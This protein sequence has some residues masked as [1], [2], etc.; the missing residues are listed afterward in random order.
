VL[1][2]G[3]TFLLPKPNNPIEHLWVVITERDPSTHE[4]VCVNISSTKPY[5]LQAD[6]TL[7][8]VAGEHSCI[9]KPSV[10]FYKDARVMRLN[11]VDKMLA[12]TQ[13]TIVCVQK[14]PC[15]TELLEKIQKHLPN[16]P[17]NKIIK[18]RCQAMWESKT[19]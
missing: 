11:D 13:Q 8:L 14:E 15:S 10:V 2:L 16:S 7:E 18:E 6:K 17:A 4:A 3:D 5:T 12:M 1:N 9:T 19:K